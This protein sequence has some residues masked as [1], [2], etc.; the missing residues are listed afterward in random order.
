MTNRENVAKLPS[1]YATQHATRSSMFE[2][3][4]ALI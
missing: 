1:G 3:F 4:L 2:L